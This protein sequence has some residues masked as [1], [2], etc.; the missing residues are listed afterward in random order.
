MKALKEKVKSLAAEY[1]S[2]IIDVRRH[3]HANPELSN[4]EYKTAEYISDLL[5]E[6]DIPFESGIFNTG[7]VAIIEGK[8][9]SKKE[10]LS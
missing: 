1:S 4:E 7:I 9:P 3:L 6:L 10:P 2:E 5:T 8:N